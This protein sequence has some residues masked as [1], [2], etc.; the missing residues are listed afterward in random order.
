M[1]RE[2]VIHYYNAVSGK[3]VCGAQ[4]S[5]GERSFSVFPEKVTCEGC[6]RV[7]GKSEGK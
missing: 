4:V 7:I 6:L 1:E 3:C 5:P 2:G